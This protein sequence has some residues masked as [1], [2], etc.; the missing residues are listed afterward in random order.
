MKNSHNVQTAL[1]FEETSEALQ[2]MRD[3]SWSAN[4]SPLEKET[5]YYLHWNGENFVSTSTAI[6]H[7]NLYARTFK[8]YEV[9]RD[10]NDVISDSGSIDPNT[11]LAS[12]TVSWTEGENTV[13]RT[14]EMLI[15]NTYEN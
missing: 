13:T 15:H 3:Q 10:A 4:I 12:I 14:T 8:L 6:L 9:K 7:Q 5:P 1:L 2:F 11:L